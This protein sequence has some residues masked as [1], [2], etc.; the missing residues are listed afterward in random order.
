MAYE[1][2]LDE[3]ERC[4]FSWAFYEMRDSSLFY[5]FGCIHFNSTLASTRFRIEPRARMTSVN[6]S[7]VVKFTLL[8]NY[9]ILIRRHHGKKKVS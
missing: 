1:F 5:S 2:I 9:F 3:S 6:F 4:I 8:W 7:A